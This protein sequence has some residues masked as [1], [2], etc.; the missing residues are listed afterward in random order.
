MKT[1]AVAFA[2]AFVLVGLVSAST[3]GCIEESCPNPNLEP[4]G[5]LGNLKVMTVDAQHH[6]VPMTALQPE[7]G[8]LEIAANKVIIRYRQNW[9]DYRV[10]Y[11]VTWES[12]LFPGDY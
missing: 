11:A 4:Q 1:E 8:T 3:P 10:K 5:P 2:G 6:E 12:G 9:V 7:R